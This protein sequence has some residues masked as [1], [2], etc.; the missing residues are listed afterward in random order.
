MF[1][2]KD[3]ADGTKSGWGVATKMNGEIVVSKITIKADGTFTASDT[4]IA[5]DSAIRAMFPDKVQKMTYEGV[6]YD[7]L[8]LDTMWEYRHVLSNGTLY[9]Y[10]DDVLVGTCKKD[11]F[12]ELSG[13]TGFASRGMNSM[14][15][16][17]GVRGAEAADLNRPNKVR[18]RLGDAN[19][20]F[21]TLGEKIIRLYT[22]ETAV[23]EAT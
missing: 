9:I 2:I 3:N 12:K 11:E 22:V 7:V 13:Y 8:K 14:I 20:N 10:L 17:T 18:V 15:Y 5:S 16:Y 23:D 21:E 4:K 19:G 1:G 6:E